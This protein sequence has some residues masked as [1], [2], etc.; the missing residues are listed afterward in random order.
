MIITSMNSR[1]TVAALLLLAS[2][3]PTSL[4][5]QTY[6]G[7]WALT[8]A[9]IETITNGTIDRGTVLI[10]G[11]RIVA[12]GPD[13]ALPDSVSVIDCSGRTVYP[14]MIDAG[15]KLGLIEIGSLDETRDDDEMGEYTP[16]AQALTAV[17]PA[18]VSIP[19]ARVAG[20]TTVLVTPSGGLFPGT[21]AVINLNGYTP[22]QMRVGSFAGVVLSF[23][24]GSRG[25]W[26]DDRTDEEIAKTARR[27]RQKLDE[28][29]RSAVL[30]TRIDSTERDGGTSMRL[31]E[32]VPEIRALLPVVR[33]EQPL[34]VEVNRAEDIDSAIAWIE[35][36]H[37]RAILSGVAEGWRV[38]DH[39]AKAGLP[40][41]VG[42]VQ[43]MPTR[44]SD[45]YDR[46]YANAGV[47]SRA[48]VQVAI[49]TNSASAVRNLP[50]QA[51]FAAAYGMGREAALRAV[52][53]VPAQMFGIDDEVGSI[54]VGKQATLFVADGDPF[55]PA[56][57]V[58]ELFIDGY[59]VPLTNR[60]T[61]LY[62]EYLHRSP[63]GDEP[64]PRAEGN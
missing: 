47:L 15:T 42:P 11:E 51:G 62:R 38:A 54:E 1:P 57:H 21:A 32:Y 52:T 26:W 39:I 61:E 23:P 59:H 43:S 56:T 17:N 4:S 30:Y 10:D 8:N 64:S 50:Y 45:R 9:R 60:Q 18:S 35:H 55:E 19:I 13:V 37:V 28:I 63:G 40:C 12:V 22:G 58:Q 24:S 16:Q 53:I 2:M 36:N 31:P 29:W 44:E 14:G 6:R 46:P 5:A 7:R 25:G 3:I 20:V 41:I 48:G 33:R 27:R 49:R 34:L